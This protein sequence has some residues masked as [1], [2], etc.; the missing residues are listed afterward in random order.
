MKTRQLTRAALEKLYPRNFEFIT[1][2][3]DVA[4]L[5]ALLEAN[6]PWW[7]DITMRQ[8]HLGSAHYATQCIYLRGP[9]GFTI[10]EYFQDISAI[11]YPLLEP[12]LPAL[13]PVVRPLL[14]CINW[15][16][17]GRILIVRLPAGAELDQHVDQGDYARHYAR[18]HIPLVTNADCALVV[19]G[20]AQHMAVGEAWWFNHHKPHYARNHGATD[21]VHLIVDA[22]SP[23]FPS[24][25]PDHGPEHTRPEH[26]HAWR[27]ARALRLAGNQTAAPGREQA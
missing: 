25:E 18:F 8:E 1:S 13:M 16:E 10:E 21:R 9:L 12:L 4:P 7:R 17:L 26:A 6:P 22:V 15:R 3:L 20:D 11:D 19:A 27:K 2:G 5:A 14:T 23:R 24:P